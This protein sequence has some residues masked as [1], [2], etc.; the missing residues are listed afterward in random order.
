MWDRVIPANLRCFSDPV[1]S[2]VRDGRAGLCRA[3]QRP[4]QPG[5]HALHVPPRWNPEERNQV[6][7]HVIDGARTTLRWG[8]WPVR[9]KKLGD[10]VHAALGN[11]F[12]KGFTNLLST[13]RQLQSTCTCYRAPVALV[14]LCWYKQWLPQKF[15]FA[16]PCLMENL[17]LAMDFGPLRRRTGYGRAALPNDIAEGSRF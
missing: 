6:R 3:P 5:V 11:L 15:S 7:R 4:A 14:G 2:V 16:I 8:H 13:G 17:L 1:C 10:L 12:R 9:G